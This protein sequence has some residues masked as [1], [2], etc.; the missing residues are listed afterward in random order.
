MIARTPATGPSALDARLLALSSSLALDLPL[1]TEDI[2][3]SVAHTIGLYQVGLL[4]AD[5]AE[6]LRA[7]LLELLDQV[8][9]GQAQLPPEED[10]H[11][12][13]EAALTQRLGAVAGRL[14][15]GRSRNDQIA[16]DI[17]LHLR[18]TARCVGGWLARLLETL[19]ELAQDNAEVLLPG[20]T[21]RQR[22]IPITVGH[23]AAAGAAALLRDARQLT[24]LL[25]ELDRCPLGAG[26][27]AASS[28]PLDR[29]AVASLLGF[30]SP[31]LNSL[32]TVGD[33]DGIVGLAYL[34]ARIHVHTSRL[35]ADVV[36]YASQEF[37]FVRL[38]D[39]IAGGSSMMP[40]KK[41][42]DVFELVRGRSA[43][44]IGDLVAALTLT[45]GLPLG[46]QRDLQEDRALLTG[47]GPHLCGTLELLDLG[48]RHLRFD[49]EAMSE[50]L[51][52]DC[53]QA[54]DLAEVLVQAGVPFRRAYQS[55]GA[56]VAAARARG[57]GLQM[58]GAEDLR[59]VIPAE[60]GGDERLVARLLERLDPAAC[61][62]ARTLPG[63][64]APEAVRQQVAELRTGVAALLQRLEQVPALSE[65]EQ[66]LRRYPLVLREGHTPAPTGPGDAA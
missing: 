29:G 16:L 47:L 44:A 63:G 9:A 34:S 7:G 33:R 40:H 2:V 60:C 49:A 17:A 28:L 26:A 59:A 1:L 20:Y 65:L 30:A 43:R 8:R 51:A 22:A 14:H 64:P 53:T 46:Y 31:T 35:A 57:H 19:C 18:E 4:R 42:P 13:V 36:D 61:V 3:G 41:N 23:W 52:R 62:S 11:M 37:G 15:T 45:R 10:V 55:I 25:G 6:M 32:D 48:L 27:L 54:T 39:A 5:E 66:R 24:F 58:L 56:L 12:A 50:A 21:H 38:D